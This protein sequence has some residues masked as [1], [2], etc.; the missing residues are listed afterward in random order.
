MNQIDYKKYN[1]KEKMRR[2]PQ[3]KKASANLCVFFALLCV[4]KNIIQVAHIKLFIT[5]F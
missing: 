5:H 4:K 3:R 2:E 1:R